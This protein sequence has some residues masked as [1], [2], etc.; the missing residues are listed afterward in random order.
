[1]KAWWRRLVGRG[2]TR[3]P[4]GPVFAPDWEPFLEKNVVL[5]ASLPGGE[6]KRLRARTMEFLS[7]KSFEGCGGLELTAEMMVTV[8][9]TASLLMLHRPGPLFPKLFSV[10]LYPSVF[11]ARHVEE[12]NSGIIH[13][14]A[15][16]TLGESWESGSLILAWDAVR[17]GDPNHTPGQN[18]VLHEF[19]HQLDL[20][21]GAEDGAPK[22]DSR[23][24]QRTWAQVFQE[25]FEERKWMRRMGYRC[26]L[27][28][29]ASTHP[30]EFFAVSTEVF[31][32]RPSRLK[33]TFPRLY[34]ELRGYFRFDP[35]DHL[36][37]EK[38]ENRVREEN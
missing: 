23:E 14:S 25:A 30:A 7:T 2:E 3:G 38:N 13:E 17:P 19:A 10:L 12:T 8:A 29:Y 28:D 36:E 24:S 15:V 6:K 37:R 34:A 33:K 22:L 5:Y 35:L 16:D 20:D 11:R 9:G 1:M 26:V 32:E 31:F 18:I 27:D 4:G 21:D